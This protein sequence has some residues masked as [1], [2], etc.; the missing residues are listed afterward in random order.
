MSSIR[1]VLEVAS[2]PIRGNQQKAAMFQFGKVM[3]SGGGRLWRCGGCGV[4]TC[5]CA[6]CAEPPGHHEATRPPQHST[7]QE[8]AILQPSVPGTTIIPAL[9]AWYKPGNFYLCLPGTKLIC[10]IFAWKTLARVLLFVPDIP[11]VVCQI[12]HQ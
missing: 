1:S 11:S 10:T 9:C 7:Q 8:L 6:R 4:G 2:P 3:K 5:G 12:Y